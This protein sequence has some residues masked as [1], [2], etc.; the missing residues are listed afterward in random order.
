MSS[1]A[2]KVMHNKLN[3][4]F[5]GDLTGVVGLSQLQTDPG[6]FGEPCYWARCCLASVS[7]HRCPITRIESTPSSRKL[8]AAF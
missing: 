8:R 3:A 6:I 2:K 4:T 5:A 1:N 7:V